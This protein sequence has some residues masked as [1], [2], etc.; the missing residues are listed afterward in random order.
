MI[1]ALRLVLTPL[2]VYFILLGKYMSAEVAF[3]GICL[4]D[5]FDGMTARMFG[6]CTHFGAIMDIIADLL[7]IFSSLA[8]LSFMNMSP[9]WLTLLVPFKFAE[10]YRTSYILRKGNRASIFVSDIPGRICAALFF[11]MPGV[12][13]LLHQ[14]TFVGSSLV[15]KIFLILILFTALTSTCL[16]CLRCIKIKRKQ[17]L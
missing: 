10:F 8:V 9:V 3:V 12:I 17:L 15:V 13:C 11:I 1:T 4:S 14:V 6:A 7:Y 16:R 5:I 2:F